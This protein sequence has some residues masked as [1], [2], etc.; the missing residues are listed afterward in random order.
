[1]NQTEAEKEFFIEYARSFEMALNDVPVLV[2][3]A[4]IQWHSMTKANLRA[5]GSTIA[6][7]LYRIDFVAFWKN[8]RYAVLIDDIS[9]YGKSNE[10][11]WYADEESYAK[12]L[13]EDRK[14]R[15]EQWQVFRIS[16]WEIRNRD[17]L[18][19]ILNDLRELMS[20]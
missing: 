5:E 20:F 10:R 16:N 8:R 7:E 19:E 6:D 12:R 14:L 3:Q 17:T 2:P 4:W 11:G 13:K 9:H 1:M 18:P 15:K